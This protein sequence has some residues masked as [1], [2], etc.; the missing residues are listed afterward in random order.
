MRGPGCPLYSRGTG[1][2]VGLLVQDCLGFGG[3]SKSVAHR[4]EADKGRI[5]PPRFSGSS[6]CS[7][8][9]STR[10]D[11]LQLEEKERSEIY[12]RS[13]TLDNS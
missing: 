10:F 11:T 12:T 2:V 8:C 7:T 3:G 5:L 4:A 13:K 9:E 1:E 6:F